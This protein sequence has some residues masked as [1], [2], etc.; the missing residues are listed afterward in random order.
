MGQV[1]RREGRYLLRTNLTGADPAELWRPDIQL[2]PVEQ[3]FKNLNGDLAIR[4]IF[5][6]I[7]SRIEAHIF[8]AFLAYCLHATLA[9]QRRPHAPGLTPRSVLDQFA[10]VQMLD[11]EIPTP[12]GRQLILT[13]HTAPEP[14]SRLLLAR[15]GLQLPAQ[16]R[17]K[18]T[19]TQAQAATLVSCRPSGVPSPEINGWCSSKGP[20]R[21]V[22]LVRRILGR[23]GDLL[24]YLG[25]FCHRDPVVVDPR[26]DLD[27]AGE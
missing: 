7:E 25:Q 13:R 4:P 15:L 1:R 21:E 12:D 5:H 16:P 27:S 26:A 9:Q 18:I 20:I 23:I 22:G 6:R 17:P 8:I 14:E 24:D 11:V 3:A 19:A 10:A 2:T